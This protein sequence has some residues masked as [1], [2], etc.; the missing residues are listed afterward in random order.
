MRVY[1]DTRRRLVDELGLEPGPALQQ[2]EQAILRQDPSLDLAAVARRASAAAPRGSLPRSRSLLAAAAAAAGVLLAGGG[3]QS[4]Q[5]QSARPARLGRAR[6]CRQRQGDRASRSCRPPCFPGSARARSGTS[7]SPATE[8]D[9]PGQR[10]GHR[11]RQ[12][13]CPVPCGLAVG[14]GS[15]WVTDCTSPTLVRIDPALD[16][17]RRP[18]PAAGPG[19]VPGATQTHERRASAPARSGS[20][21]AIA[22]PSYV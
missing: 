17:R 10:E 9:R 4:S 14:E 1:A 5:A 2:L 11:H 20:G 12:H 19:G 16:R 3:T 21:R 13:G 18:L 7:R 15:V 8:Q 6:L 22:N